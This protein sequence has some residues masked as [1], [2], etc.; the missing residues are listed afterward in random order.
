MTRTIQTGRLSIASY[1]SHAIGLCLTVFLA[2]VSLA[3]DAGLSLDIRLTKTVFVECEEIPVQSVLSNKSTTEAAVE[4]PFGLGLVVT[5]DVYKLEEE[6]KELYIKRQLVGAGRPAWSPHTLQ[7][8]PT[9]SAASSYDLLHHYG[10]LAP[11]KYKIRGV[12]HA[13]DYASEDFDNPKFQVL[14]RYVE[15]QVTAPQGRTLEA[16]KLLGQSDSEEIALK[17]VRDYLDSPYVIDARRSLITMFHARKDRDR[18]IEQCEAILAANPTPMR[19]SLTL[20]EEGMQYYYKG[21]KAT[22]AEKMKA[23]GLQNGEAQAAEWLAT[24][25]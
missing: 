10:R 11:G 20:F 5:F 24:T 15:F 17:I 9:S 6:G 18:V 14:S 12:Y 4:E 25:E 1:S 13:K 7:L 21:D 2:S 3:Q 8:Q 19:R 23:S 22:A 16:L